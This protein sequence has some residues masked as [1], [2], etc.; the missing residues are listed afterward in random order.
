M[1]IQMVLG[2]AAPGHPAHVGQLLRSTSK[3]R[4]DLFT[5]TLHGPQFPVGFAGI[6]QQAVDCAAHEHVAALH[7]IK[8]GVRLSFQLSPALNFFF[9]Y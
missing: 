3:E 6:R 2:A 1:L 7:E 8:M 9:C 4:T 5:V